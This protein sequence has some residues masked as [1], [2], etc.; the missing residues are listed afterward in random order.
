[1]LIKEPVQCIKQKTINSIALKAINLHGSLELDK[2]LNI[3]CFQV[4]NIES[5]IASY[6]VQ[7]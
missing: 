2:K 5:Y 4:I 3:K 7:R 6:T 1:M